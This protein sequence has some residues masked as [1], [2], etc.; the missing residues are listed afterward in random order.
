MKQTKKAFTLVELAIVLVIIGILLGAVLK[1]QS[2]I[3]NAKEKRLHSLIQELQAGVLT[4]YDK[5]N[6]LPGDDP[7]AQTHLDNNSTKNGNGNGLINNLITNCSDNSKESCAAWEHLRLADILSGSGVTNPKHPYGGPVA[8]GYAKMPSGD[9]SN[10]LY[11]YQI[12]KKVAKDIDQKYDD[13]K[14]DSGDIQ[15]DENHKNLYVKLD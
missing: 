5:Y 11:F 15:Y 7:Q 1:S 6:A 14:F 3:G 2:L 8:I 9:Y 4:Y 13:G 12:P 10:L